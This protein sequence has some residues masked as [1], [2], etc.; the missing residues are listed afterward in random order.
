MQS[1]LVTGGNGFIGSHM[2]NLL[3]KQ[4]YHVVIID[5]LSNSSYREVPEATFIV[6]DISDSSL[7]ESIFKQYKIY[8]VI[9]F[10]GSIEVSESAINPGKFYQNNVANSINLLNCMIANDIK[11]FIFSSSAAIYGNPTDIPLNE[12]H[13]KN[14][15]NPYGFSKLMVENILKDFEQSHD[16]K[17]IA[18]RYFNA[19]GADVDGLLGEQHDPETHLIP[20]LLEVVNG[21]RPYISIYGD[22]YP[23]T[24]G[25]CV[26]DYVHVQDLCEAHLLAMESLF[27][28]NKS[29]AY[30]L[31]SGHGYTVKEIINKVS[32]IAKVNIPYKIQPRR[33]GDP[34]SL[35]ADSS[36]AFKELN[37]TPKYSDLHTIINTAYNFYQ[38]LL[39]NEASTSVEIVI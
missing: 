36:K 34:A 33:P 10:A 20:I 1:I 38:K 32:E 26:R 23:T 28:Q 11:Y 29:G 13:S 35:I 6:G 17:Y 9:H 15:V 39:S 16:L 21:K 3:I 14:P 12:N 19:A 22:D 7:L 30:N 25:T 31:G 2:V 5:N 37:W 24:D 8:G 4:K 27:K 18:L